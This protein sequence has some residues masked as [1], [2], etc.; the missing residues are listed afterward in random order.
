MRVVVA[1][2]LKKN[3][4][5]L[6]TRDIVLVP[7]IFSDQKDI[8]KKLLAEI[9]GNDSINTDKLWKSWHG[10]SHLIADDHSQNW[11]AKCPTFNMVISRIQEYF[12]MDI[13]AT[14]FNWF[15]DDSEW[16]PFHHDAA[17]VKPDKAKTQNFTVGI[18]FGSERDIAFEENNSKRVVTFP[19]PDGMTYCFTKD[20][21]IN[22]KH[23]VPQL[24]PEK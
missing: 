22:W 15:R 20:I 5:K 14:R 11:K 24:P 18:S 9:E 21:N 6:T 13:K 4:L 7:H 23:G 8:Y 19:L 3:N 17:A 16:K 10:D 2:G 1:T 12:D